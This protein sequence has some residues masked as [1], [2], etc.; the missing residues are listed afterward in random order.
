MKPYVSGWTKA[1]VSGSTQV[2]SNV[3]EEKVFELIEVKC[4]T[5]VAWRL[6]V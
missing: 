6:S 2:Q 3:K 5:M 4:D 1:N